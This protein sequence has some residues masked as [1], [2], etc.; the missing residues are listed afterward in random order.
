MSL[1]LFLVCLVVTLGTVGAALLYLRGITRRVLVAQCGTDTGAE[2]WLRAADVLA[3]AGSLI[4]V[5]AFGGVLPGADWVQQLRLVLGLAL[6]GVFVTV[7]LVASS[8][9][10]AI[11][12][13]QSGEAS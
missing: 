9:W 12:A 3:L 1:D 5:L 13:A 10:R 6:A 2:F 4:L 11:P 8:V 7:V